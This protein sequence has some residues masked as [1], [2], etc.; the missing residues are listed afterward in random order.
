MQASICVMSISSDTLKAPFCKMQLK[1]LSAKVVCCN[2]LLTNASVEANSVEMPDLGLHCL[3][4]RLR[5]HF[6]RQR[7]PITL[8]CGCSFNGEVCS[9]ITNVILTNESVGAN[10]VDPDQSA[11]VRQSDLGLQCL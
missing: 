4:K 11:L 10:S 1:M 3:I 5:N 8:C 6:S 9:I 2:I 7:T